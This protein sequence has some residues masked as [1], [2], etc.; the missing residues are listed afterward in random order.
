MNERSAA[1]RPPLRADG[2]RRDPGVPSTD[3]VEQEQVDDAD[4]EPAD[5]ADQE[6]ADEPERTASGRRMPGVPKTTGDP[7]A[8]AAASESCGSAAA[9]EQ[10]DE[11]QHD[12]TTAFTF[13][14]L[15]KL[16]NP[17]GVLSAAR[18]WSD[19]VGM[20]GEADAPTM[21]TFLRRRQLGVDFFDGGSGGPEAR[22]SE[23][24]TGDSPFREE[25]LVLVGLPGQSWIA[26]EAGWEFEPLEDAA[27][28]A[29]WTLE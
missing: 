8:E 7:E 29:G 15:Q 25:R 22:L 12:L 23:I 6:P 10:P 16:A 4:K 2:G 24:A 27:E 18:S 20:V 17:A 21:N 26:E 11:P 1:E 13:E 28:Q 14:A 19:W 3:D 9:T 5:D